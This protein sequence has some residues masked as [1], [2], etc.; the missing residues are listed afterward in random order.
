MT[1]PRH[2]ILPVCTSSTENSSTTQ[3]AMSLKRLA[4]FNRT[5]RNVINSCFATWTFP[6]VLTN[7]VLQLVNNGRAVVI[8]ISLKRFIDFNWTHRNVNNSCSTTRTFHN[9]LE[10]FFVNQVLQLINNCRAV[11]ITIF[12]KRFNWIHRNVIN[13]CFTTRTFPNYLKYVTINQVYQLINNCRPVVIAMF[14]KRFINFNR[15]HHKASIFHNILE[16][17]S[18]NQVYQLI[19]KCKP[20]VITIF[21]KHFT[22]FNWTHRNVNNSCF[23]TWTFPNTLKFSTNQIHSIDWSTT[24]DHLL[25]QYL[26]NCS[27]I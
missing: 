12:L 6:N 27:P 21:L 15:T 2:Y 3:L 11:V 25:S 17:F 7:Q 26:Q 23:T 10:Y 4:N 8:T 1:L 14:L 19:N 18:T 5:H 9:I 16:Y 13:L 20:V 24:A 22:N